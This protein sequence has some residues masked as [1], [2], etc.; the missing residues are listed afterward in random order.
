MEYYTEEF[1]KQNVSLLEKSFEKDIRNYSINE[2]TIKI[3][4]I[5]ELHKFKNHKQVGE[6]GLKSLYYSYNKSI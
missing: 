5:V 3:K 1:L 2:L 4:C 6:K